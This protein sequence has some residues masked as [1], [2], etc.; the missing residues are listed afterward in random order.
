MQRV[1]Y[2]N[3]GREL[4]VDWVKIDILGVFFWVLSLEAC[5]KSKPF[6]PQ[7]ELWMLVLRLERG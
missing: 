5:A 2:F 3:F 6:D 4:T 7:L 1:S